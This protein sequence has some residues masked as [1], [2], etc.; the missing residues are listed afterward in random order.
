[1]ERR[2]GVS[3]LIVELRAQEI[4]PKYL[5][6]DFEKILKKHEAFEPRLFNKDAHYKSC[7]G[8]VTYLI[9]VTYSFYDFLVLISF[10][11]FILCF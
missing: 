4:D 9:S 3:V 1:M 11:S 5:I 6:A 7:V 8:E 2:C 10:F